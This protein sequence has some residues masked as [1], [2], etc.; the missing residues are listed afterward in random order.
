[1]QFITIFY[2]RGKY[3]TNEET[4]KITYGFAKSNNEEKEEEKERKV[5]CQEEL[6][7]VQVGVQ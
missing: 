2:I 4:K 6:D 3:E 5:I 1:M 7:M